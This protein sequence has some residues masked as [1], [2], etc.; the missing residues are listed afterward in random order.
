M[1]KMK[2][3]KLVLGWITMCQKLED[4]ELLDKIAAEAT[5]EIEN[6]IVEVEIKLKASLNEEQRTLFDKYETL[7]L[8]EMMTVQSMTAEVFSTGC[9]HSC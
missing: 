4:Q 8:L 5:K 6:D 3:E 1:G 9:F 2:I 7:N